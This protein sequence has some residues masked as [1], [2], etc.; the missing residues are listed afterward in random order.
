MKFTDVQK[1]WALTAS[2]ASLLSFNLVLSLSGQN[3]GSM[4][5]ASEQPTF[6]EVKIDG[7]TVKVMFEK[8]GE[9][10]T[11]ASIASGSCYSCGERINLPI[12]FSENVED[13]KTALAVAK[14]TSA[15][16]K[17]SDEK[18]EKVA[19]NRKEREATRLKD[20]DNSVDEGKE[21]LKELTKNCRNKAHYKK[22]DE[23]LE[24]FS[25]GLVR[26]LANDEIEYKRED[27]FKLFANDIASP[28]M[29]LIKSAPGSEKYDLAKSIIND[30]ASSIPESYNYLRQSLAKV[31]AKIVANAERNVQAKFNEF[32]QADQMAKANPTNTAL[33]ERA[34]LIANSVND[35]QTQTDKIANDL[36]VNL[37]NGLADAVSNDYVTSTLADQYLKVDYF[38]TIDPIIKGLKQ[39]SIAYLAGNV[40]GSNFQI[41]DI[42]IGDGS[43]VSLSDGSMLLITPANN[44]VNGTVRGSLTT[45]SGN[46]PRRNQ[47]TAQDVIIEGTTPMIQ[48]G[49]TGQN[50]ARIVVINAGQQ[51][52]G[53]RQMVP[54]RVQQQPLSAP[55]LNG[56][57]FR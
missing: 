22:S 15:K 36:G 40:N 8:R 33:R 10:E 26:L 31:N 51:A 35:L 34:N 29:E 52:V 42:E 55:R 38:G 16:Q 5:L 3:L 41:P 43:T 13:M 30:L 28:L 7:K 14:A 11:T 18:T 57:Q 50:T 6:S 54:N 32:K 56:S 47:L 19:S 9:E 23:R 24:C 44:V 27:V 1:K 53:Q 17:S 39:S 48:P 25:D 45:S 49:Q 46:G 2:L 4:N 21:A 37:R 12:Q 20:K